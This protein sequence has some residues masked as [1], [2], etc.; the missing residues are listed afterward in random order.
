MK[1]IEMQFVDVN[2]QEIISGGGGGRG[3]LHPLNDRATPGH[4]QRNHVQIFAND[5]V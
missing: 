5:A 4:K 2:M 3:M 1:P